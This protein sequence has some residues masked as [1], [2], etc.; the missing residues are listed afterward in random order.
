[1]RSKLFNTIMI[2]TAACF[3]A[4]ASS[5]ILAESAGLQAS[6]RG[7]VEVGKKAIPAVVSIQV[8]GS[9]AKNSLANEDSDDLFNDDFL[10]R[11]FSFNR[12]PRAPKPFVGQGS[13]FLISKD[14][15]LIT[16]RHVIHETSEILVTLND[17]RE[18][19]GQVIGQDPNTDI[20]L[21]KIDANDL[22]FLA[23]GN[24][25]NLEVGEPV[26]AIGNPFGLQSTM[27]AGIVSAK[28]RNNLD[29]AAEEDFIQTDASINRGMSGGPLLNLDSKVIGIN[30]AIVTNMG[31]G[32]LGIAFAIPSNIA[33][34]V[35]DQL[36]NKGSVTR[37]FIGIMLQDIDQDLAQAFNL[38]Q[39]GGAL[40]ADVTRNSP[41]ER[42][43]IK[44]G[45]VIQAYDNHPVPNVA[46]LR[47]A[48]ALMLPG[49]RTTLKVL[50]NGTTLDIP[51]EIGSFPNSEPMAVRISDSKLGFEVQ[52]LTPELARS[53]NLTEEAGLIVSKV[54][55]G[56]PAAWAGISKG[57]Q[58][59]AVNQQ[60][61]NSVEQFNMMLQKTAPGRPILLLVKQ[62]DLIRYVSLK[63]N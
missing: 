51:I 38:K 47:K 17:G 44:Q 32:S 23:L 61:V 31:S 14:G 29:I 63:V 12:R 50:R 48:I 58:I 16:N 62:G 24:S 2:V 18:F 28:G 42:A 43:G 11:F 35:I 52:D 34:H 40:V 36:K 22:P 55:P 4:S 21:V 56:S 8:K 25:D 5:P 3:M 6:N 57:S 19:I 37:G 10:Q 39:R 1:M 30:T 41:A 9:S 13:G 33:A 59:V 49:S 53:L 26:A 60:K 45:D 27:T 54:E 15:Y 20:A 46:S 7:F